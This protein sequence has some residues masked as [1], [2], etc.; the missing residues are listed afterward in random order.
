DYLEKLAKSLPK[1]IKE[2]KI[3]MVLQ[4]GYVNE[5]NLIDLDKFFSNISTKSSTVLLE[6]VFSYNAQ[7]VSKSIQFDEFGNPEKIEIKNFK[8][9]INYNSSVDILF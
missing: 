1:S 2:I 7:V 6:N 4:L 9:L 8:N 5:V 3:W